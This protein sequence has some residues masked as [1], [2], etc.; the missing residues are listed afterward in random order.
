MEFA[1]EGEINEVILATLLVVSLL[2]FTLKSVSGMGTGL[3]IIPLASI[4]IDPKSAVILSSLMA[5]VGGLSMVRVDPVRLAPKFWVPV[6]VVMVIGTIIGAL[7]LNR[8]PIRGFSIFMSAVFVLSGIWLFFRVSLPAP[9]LSSGRPS[10]RPVDLVVGGLSGLMGGFVGINAAPLVLHFGRCMNKRYL[11]RFLVLIFLFAVVA[12]ITTFALTGLIDLRIL[13][14]GASM[15]PGMALGIY[16]GNH[17]FV[18][19]S[20]AAFRWI[21]GVFLLICAGKILY[22]FAMT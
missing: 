19:L 11:R 7:M 2:A 16:L 5:V 17:L 8:V 3:V 18:R 13:L 4:V 20:E 1:G 22:R 9:E 21:L 14:M 10:A 6:A 15:I 12:Q